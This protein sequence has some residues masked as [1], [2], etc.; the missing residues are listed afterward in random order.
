MLLHYWLCNRTLFTLSLHVL[1]YPCVFF[2]CYGFLYRCDMTLNVECGIKAIYR[3]SCLFLY[4]WC[5]Y[6]SSGWMESE[7]I[8]AVVDECM[9]PRHLAG[10]GP[11]LFMYQV[12][13]LSASLYDRTSQMAGWTWSLSQLR[14]TWMSGVHMTPTHPAG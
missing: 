5:A 3:S 7:C 4:S 13:L 8:E 2:L 12:L 9:V 10:Y 6:I 14:Q 1:H 11:V